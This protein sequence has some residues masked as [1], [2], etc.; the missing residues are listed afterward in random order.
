MVWLLFAMSDTGSVDLSI[1]ADNQV[2]EVHFDGERVPIAPAEWTTVR[3][4][5]M[6]T[7]TR[8]IAIKCLDQG[9]SSGLLFAS[10]LLIFFNDQL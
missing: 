9:V 5:A 8:T 2:L 1:T 4:V 3:K 7:R 10:T 6:P